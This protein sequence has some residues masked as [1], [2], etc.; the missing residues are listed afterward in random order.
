MLIID[1]QLLNFS[2]RVIRIISLERLFPSSIANTLYWLQN[3][4]SD[5]NIL[6]QGLSEPESYI[7]LVNKFKKIM[8][9]TDFSDQFRKM[10]IC[11]KHIGY[12]LNVMRQYVCYV[13]NP[14]ITV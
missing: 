2:N 6:H 3:S 5:L 10:I 11:N 7:D 12:D 1:V 9:R 8:C 4:M 13:I 14:T